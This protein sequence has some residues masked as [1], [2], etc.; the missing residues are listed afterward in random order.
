[1]LDSGVTH[2]TKTSSVRLGIQ[3]HKDVWTVDVTRI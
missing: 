1:M 2:V 3:E